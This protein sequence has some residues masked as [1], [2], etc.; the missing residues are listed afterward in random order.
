M[1]RSRIFSNATGYI[2]IVAG[3]VGIGMYVPKVGL[4][5]SILSVVVMHVW[6][7]MIALKLLSF[8]KPST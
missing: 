4:F 3:V 7:V 6:Y 2:R 5:I 1:L 8:S